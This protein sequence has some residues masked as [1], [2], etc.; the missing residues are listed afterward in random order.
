MQVLE[1]TANGHGTRKMCNV[2]KYG[3]PKKGGNKGWQPI[4][5]LTRN[6]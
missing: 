5:R 3:F 4:K 2:D 6:M 1:I